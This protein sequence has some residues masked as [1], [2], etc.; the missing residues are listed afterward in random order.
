MR[1]P[2]DDGSIKRNALQRLRDSFA[3]QMLDAEA[4]QG[5]ME[6]D[7]PLLAQIREGAVQGGVMPIA[8]SAGKMGGSAKTLA[9]QVKGKILSNNPAL[10][11]GA[12]I[13]APMRV[14]NEAETMAANAKPRLSK[15]ALAELWK[16]FSGQ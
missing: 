9:E 8:G 1:M 12:T 15:E 14:L 5:S 3:N 4:L 2:Q 13:Q 7:N 16:K 10:G 11:T 6:R